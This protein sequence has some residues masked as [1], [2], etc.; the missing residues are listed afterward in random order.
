MVAAK[1]RGNGQTRDD[2]SGLSA[3]PIDSLL[4]EARLNDEDDF[5]V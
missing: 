3:M 5:I 4:C 1:D 2:T